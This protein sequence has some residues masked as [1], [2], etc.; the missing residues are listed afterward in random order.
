MSQTN[1]NLLELGINFQ[2]SRS[3]ENSSV[4]CEYCRSPVEPAYVTEYHKI[5]SAVDQLLSADAMP[6]DGPQQ[7]EGVSI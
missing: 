6:L 2:C 3:Q 4:E 5:L 7:V 1:A